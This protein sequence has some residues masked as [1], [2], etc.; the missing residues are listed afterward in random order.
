M[1]AENALQSAKLDYLKTHHGSL[2][3]P[4][5]WST[6]ELTSN[7]KDLRLAPL[8]KRIFWEWIPVLIFLIG[9]SGSLVWIAVKKR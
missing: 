9:V 6:Y 1:S 2:T 8:T 3:H 7:V 5:Y 4:M